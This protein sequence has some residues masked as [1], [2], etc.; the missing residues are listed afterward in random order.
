MVG[1][2]RDITPMTK[3]R[4]LLSLQKTAID[5]SLTYRVVGKKTDKAGILFAATLKHIDH[6][7]DSN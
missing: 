5:G 4:P 3:P 6:L 2:E 1:N 7:S